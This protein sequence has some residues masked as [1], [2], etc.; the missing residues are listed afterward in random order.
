M[1]AYT[2]QN[3]TYLKF[4]LLTDK[5]EISTQDSGNTKTI[6]QITKADQNLS[7]MR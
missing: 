4:I 1:K 7:S 6:L 3:V 2:K 5:K